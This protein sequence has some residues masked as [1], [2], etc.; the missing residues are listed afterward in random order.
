[1]WLSH[2]CLGM[3]AGGWFAHIHYL[4]RIV[5]RYRSIHSSKGKL[6]LYLYFPCV[7]LSWIFTTWWACFHQRERTPSSLHSDLSLPSASVW[8]P[9]GSRTV[10]DE[11]AG[12]TGVHMGSI[13]Y[14]LAT[15]QLKTGGRLRLVGEIARMWGTPILQNCHIITSELNTHWFDPSINFR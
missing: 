4:H 2:L 3:R 13:L 6:S 15:A 5:S 10:L 1:M 11:P 12:N 14:N 9:S 7:Q 8:L